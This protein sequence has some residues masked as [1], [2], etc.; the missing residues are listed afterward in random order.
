[1]GK[2]NT[3]SKGVLFLI[4]LL[5]NLNSLFS[6]D[7][8]INQKSE[9]SYL[10]YVISPQW[11]NL[12][13]NESYEF[14]H[15]SGF[16]NIKTINN[17]GK[18]IV[19]G[20]IKGGEYLYSRRLVFQNK[21][22]IE[23]S[24]GIEFIQPCVLCLAQEV[25]ERLKNNPV[26]QKISNDGVSRAL[27]HNSKLKDVFYKNH[28]MSL[29]KDGI[30]SPLFGDINDF[31]FSFS[32]SI[33]TD[34]CK[35]NRFSTLKLDED[36]IYNFYSERKVIINDEIYLVGNYNLEEVNQYDLRIMVDVFLLDCKSHDI[37]VKKG[38][39]ITSFET[40]DG[41][42]LGL[43][44]GINNDTR[45]EL[46]IDPEKWAN[47]S[48]PKRWYLIYHELGHDVLNLQH[49]NGGKMMFNFAD[50]GYSWKEFWEDRKYMFESYKNYKK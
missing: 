45:I 27:D 49:G 30:E 38:E 12:N 28:I 39:V 36:N 34:N 40:L 44:Y 16:T 13:L 50:K 32:H 17:A 46:K 22:I 37:V 11:R 2:I 3:K 24:D 48:M 1:M 19:Y 4:C 23:Y 8:Y 9:A 31:G 6:Q 20:T 14:L 43:S 33:V 7:F 35:I 10:N 47:A 15:N 29:S 5:F 25:K 18:E 21:L 41:R 26:M 42:T